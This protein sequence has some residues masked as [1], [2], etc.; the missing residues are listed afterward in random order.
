MTFLVSGIWCWYLAIFTYFFLWSEA[1]PRNLSPCLSHEELEP[2]WFWATSSN[3]C[4][5][6]N[7]LSVLLT[8]TFCGCPTI[9]PM[10]G[11]SLNFLTFKVVGNFPNV[12]Y[13]LQ[14]FPCPGVP[15]CRG[16]LFLTPCYIYSLDSE[17]GS[18]LVQWILKKSTNPED[19]WLV[20]IQS[21][22]HSLPTLTLKL[23]T[24]WQCLPLI[25]CR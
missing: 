7:T 23:L 3:S 12:C 6:G 24:K 19:T 1:P 18:H 20:R 9:Q 13:A 4:C 22:S 14:L 8:S 21:S 2:V 16:C 25:S 11:S 15:A 17:R 5:H 10:H